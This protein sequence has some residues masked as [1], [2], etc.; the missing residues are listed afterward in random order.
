MFVYLFKNK[1]FEGRNHGQSLLYDFK[2]SKRA[3]H[4][5]DTE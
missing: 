2:D 3:M 1:I 4:Y 5:L